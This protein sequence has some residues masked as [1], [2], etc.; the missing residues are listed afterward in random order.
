MEFFRR[1]PN[2]LLSLLVTIKE[3]WL[4]HYDPETKQETMEWRHSGSP[5]PKNFRVQNSAGKFLAS[6]SFNQDGILF[7]DYLPKGQTMNADYYSTLLVQLKDILKKKRRG[8]FTK[9]FL[10]LHDNAPPHRALTSLPGLPLSRSPTLFSESGPVGLPSV[11]WTERTIE[12]SPF[13]FGREGHCCCVDL[14]GR[15][16]F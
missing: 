2:N 1:D 16:N 15:T 4:Y 8:M 6:I 7:T 3:T 14:V 5:R 13:F 10:F 11:P 9:G 12:R